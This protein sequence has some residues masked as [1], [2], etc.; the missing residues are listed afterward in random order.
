MFDLDG[1]VVGQRWK[2]PVQS[3]HKAHRMRWSVEEIRIA[4]SDVLGPRRHLLTNVFH[5]DL[6]LYYPKLALIHRNHRTMPAQ[7]LAAAARLG[8]ARSFCG[9]IHANV[10]IL[11]ERR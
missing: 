7:M 5:H 9:P 10:R 4:E 8:V 2:F 3:F 6:G 11:S 1:R